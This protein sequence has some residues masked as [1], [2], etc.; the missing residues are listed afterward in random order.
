MTSGRRRAPQYTRFCA[1]ANLNYL[2]ARSAL[3]DIPWGWMR[4]GSNIA[5]TAEAVIADGEKRLAAG[6]GN[7]VAKPVRQENCLAA[8][9][10]SH[11]GGTAD[12]ANTPQQPRLNPAKLAELRELAEPGEPDAACEFIELY[13]QDTPAYLERLRAALAATAPAA[14]KDN[15]HSLKGSSRNLGAERLAALCLQLE[16]S[17]KESAFGRAGALLAQVEAEFQ[18]VRPLLEAELSAA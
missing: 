5:M 9:A 14:L 17:A 1:N 11:A 6:M 2:K 12:F 8:L 10:Q 3:A 4:C 16:A 13:L 15:A 7:C 18:A